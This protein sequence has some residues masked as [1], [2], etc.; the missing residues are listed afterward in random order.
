METRRH[1]SDSLAPRSIPAADRGERGTHP[2]ATS[3]SGRIAGI[4][5]VAP[6]LS[7]RA[8][9]LTPSAIEREM[10]QT[11]ARGGAVHPNRIRTTARLRATVSLVLAAG[12][13][14]LA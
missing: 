9:Q 1:R 13:A 2:G 5:R 14:G 4:R 8:R 7:A 6:A 3:V 10:D 11:S 12:L